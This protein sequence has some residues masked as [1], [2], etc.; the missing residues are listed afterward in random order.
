MCQP[1]I[2]HHTPHT[3]RDDGGGS[4]VCMCV[5]VSVCVRGHVVL[6]TVYDCYNEYIRRQRNG[7]GEK[8][9][10]DSI[11]LVCHSVKQ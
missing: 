6:L 2:K 8:N 1:V 10:S 3:V 9:I 5:C 7:D 4:G 11:V